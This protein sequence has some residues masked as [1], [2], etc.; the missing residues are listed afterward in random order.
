MNHE[1]RCAV[2]GVYR[3]HTMRVGYET[4]GVEAA[5]G[6]MSTRPHLTGRRTLC[7]PTSLFVLHTCPHYLSGERVHRLH[8]SGHPTLRLFE[9]PNLL[10]EMSLERSASQFRPLPHLHFKGLLHECI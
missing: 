9:R 5:L 1:E 10:R 8:G 7:A 4:S 3:R 6:P 2:G